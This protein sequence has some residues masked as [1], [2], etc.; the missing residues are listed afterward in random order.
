MEKSEIKTI[1]RELQ[2]KFP[3]GSSYTKKL[4]SPRGWWMLQDT[5]QPITVKVLERRKITIDEQFQYQRHLQTWTEEILP[6]WKKFRRK[7][8]RITFLVLAL[9]ML[10]CVYGITTNSSE[11]VR[12]SCE[13][14]IFLIAYI[15][16]I[17]FEAYFC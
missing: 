3:L 2:S 11:F 6:V 15:A 16:M 8:L 13:L 9:V 1:V 12:I 17:C 7:R 10:T 4:L 5:I 14:L